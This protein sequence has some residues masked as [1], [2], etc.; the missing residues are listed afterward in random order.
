MRDTAIVFLAHTWSEALARRFERLRR[1]TSPDFDCFA[2]IQDDDE[3]VL[4]Q[5]QSS[6]KAMGAERAL[7]RFSAATLATQLDLRYFGMR[8]VLSN[9]H[10]PL[11]LFSRSHRYSYYWQVEYDVE[12]R[13]SWRD[14]FELYRPSEAAF[15]ASHFHRWSDWPTWFWWPSL[16]PPAGAVVSTEQLFKAFM[17]VAR[18]SHEA[19]LV[20]ERA[21]REGWLGHFEAVVPTVLMMNGHNLEDLNVRGKSYI[22]GFQDPVALL[23]LQSTLRARPPVGIDEFRNRGQGALLFHPVKDDV[24]PQ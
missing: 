4:A 3:N 16:M 21:H 6:L 8:Q 13:G 11:L 17:P 2:L 1:E 10:F 22:G 18:F 14:F 24:N 12:L 9:T 15:V 5:W 23:P 19:L 7:F 20:V